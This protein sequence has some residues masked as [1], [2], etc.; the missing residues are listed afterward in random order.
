MKV[1]IAIC[2]SD[3]AVDEWVPSLSSAVSCLVEDCHAV[4]VITGTTRDAPIRACRCHED[5]F[6]GCKPSQTQPSWP[7]DAAK[8]L[9]M[10]RAVC[11]SLERKR[12]TAIPLNSSDAEVIQVRRQYCE[13]KR[14]L[15]ALEALTCSSR[16]LD[17]ICSNK[18]I[19]VISNLF[20]CGCGTNFFIGT[21]L[22]AAVCARDWKADALMYFSPENGVT[23][24]DG[25]RV[26]WLDVE[27]ITPLLRDVALPSE[28]ADRL[29][30]AKVALQGGVGRVRLMPLA[31]I[32]S[33]HELY[34]QALKDGTEVVC[35]QR[36]H[37]GGPEVSV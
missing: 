10:N 30:A 12:L 32:G 33:L 28:V 8:V 24:P 29:Q 7:C 6:H 17:I 22:M 37:T 35:C 14:S 18:G 25:A 2:A 26:R 3:V 19:P 1:V 4:V 34:F 5:H 16:W 31:K 36:A 13:A 23:A 9:E 20:L 21:N 27:S 11:R 15:V